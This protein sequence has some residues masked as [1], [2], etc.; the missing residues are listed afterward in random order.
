MIKEAIKRVVDGEDLTQEESREVMCDVM[1][2]EATDAQIAALITALRIKGETVSEVTG[3]AQTM[4]E[5]AVKIRTNAGVVLDTCG[6]GGDVS[7]TFN[8]STAC[9]IVAAGAGVTVAKHGNRSVSSQ[10]GSADVL[11]ELGVSISLTPEIVEKSIDEIGI[12]FLFAP[13]F[14]PAMKYAIGPRREIGIRTVFNILGPLTNPASATHQILG[15]YSPDLLEMMAKVLSG[16]GVKRALIVHGAHGLDELSIT[17]TNRVAEVDGDEIKLFDIDP[18]S[19]GL[20]RADLKDLKGG[21]ASDNA[22]MLRSIFA[23]AG[24]PA[25]DAVILN[26]GAALYIS[27]SARD[28][29]EGLD[30]A[31]RVIDSGQAKNKL[32]EL[33]AF[34]Q[35]HNQQ[36]G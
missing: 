6:T 17:G 19:L 29:P 2:G 7:G 36:E 27:E 16:L 15:V 35:K 14:H 3:F 22:D 34:S 18:Q 33:V 9:A 8:I 23:G 11:E 28:L 10:C 31:A 30:L 13:M 4:R 12:G 20:S 25:R 1:S 32:D 21:S 5:F 26:A 24:G